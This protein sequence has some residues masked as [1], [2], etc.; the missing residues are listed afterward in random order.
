VVE[1]AVVALV[2]QNLRSGGDW[3]KVRRSG[4]SL[5]GDQGLHRDGDDQGNGEAHPTHQRH[6]TK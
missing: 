5:R 3:Q 2:N 1:G 4:S 6:P